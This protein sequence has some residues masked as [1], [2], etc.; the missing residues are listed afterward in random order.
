MRLILLALLVFNFPVI[1]QEDL[2]AK[3]W[4]ENMSQALREQEF[5][6]SLIQLQADHIRPLVYIHGKI[7]DQEV[8]FLE[9]L[10]GP[11]KNAVRVGT[12]VT[13]IEHDQ[14]AYSVRANRIQGILPPAFAAN[15]SKLES[16]YQFVLGGRSRLAGRP[17]QLVRIIPN[18]NFR[19][20]Y[21]VW[22]DMESYLP[23]RY[24]MLTQDKQLLEQ[25]LVVELLV[26]DAPPAIL[27]EAYKQEWP[28][29]ASQSK[30][31]DGDNWTFNWLP[32]GFEI[33]V[34]DSHR[35]MG[36]HEA[37]EY[38]ALSDG[39]AN[40]SVYVARVGDTKMP[41]EL[42]TRNGLSLA[43]EVVGNFEVVAVGKVPTE[44]LTR[45]AKSISIQ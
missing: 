29:V 16:G 12:T 31:D 8:A 15:I 45:V 18:D 33:L 1:A 37:V 27:T 32:E 17:S 44:T 39:M 22:L 36:S 11:P 3:A 24:D 14:P 2:S 23:L 41:Q 19:Y 5:K 35:L 30:R 40:I 7:E 28:A 9:H 25:I 38:I 21:Q 10:N 34:K 6:M 4:L 26:L 43:T 20:G 42:V 13:F